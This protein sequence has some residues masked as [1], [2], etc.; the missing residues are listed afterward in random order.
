[1]P[2]SNKI[3]VNKSAYEILLAKEAKLEALEA[4]GVDNWTGY[5]DAMEY[6]EELENEKA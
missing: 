2:E 1:M 5:G 4:H 6:L 3:V